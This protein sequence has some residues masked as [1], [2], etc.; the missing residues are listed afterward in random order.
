MQK[1]LEFSPIRCHRGAAYEVYKHSDW[2]WDSSLSGGKRQKWLLPRTRRQKSHSHPQS[3]ERSVEKWLGL[4][5]GKPLPTQGPTPGTLLTQCPGSK[6][7]SQVL[8]ASSASSPEALTALSRDQEPIR[9]RARPRAPRRG[10]L[11]SPGVLRG[12]P[13]AASPASVG[14]G[15]EVTEE[16][17]PGL[18]GTTLL[19]VVGEVTVEQEKGQQRQGPS[20]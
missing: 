20:P 15:G 11:G 19:T 13:V 7:S 6:L 14:E 5:D 4:S 16:R 18:G 3:K 12:Q 1:P 8:S 2:K 10:Q 17:R 9:D